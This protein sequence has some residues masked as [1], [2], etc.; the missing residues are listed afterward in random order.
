MMR[1]DPPGCADTP[2]RPCAYPCRS[3]GR[4]TLMTEASDMP[5][6]GETLDDFLLVEELG[7]GSFAT[8]FLARQRSMQRTVA[9]KV[10]EDV[11]YPTVCGRLAP[12]RSE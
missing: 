6:V 1:A 7:E 12:T 3:S 5:G 11:G 9:L 10:S 8:V 4:G 2:D